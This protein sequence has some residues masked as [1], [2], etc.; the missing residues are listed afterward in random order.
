MVKASVRTNNIGI[1]L[2]W[3][4]V[5]LA[6][7]LLSSVL[8]IDMMSAFEILNKPSLSPPAYVFP[9]AWSIL[10]SLMGV[11][12]LLVYRSNTNSIYRSYGL[13]FNIIQLVLN[14]F[15]SIIFFNYKNYELALIWLVMLW[16]TVLAMLVYY[17]KVNKLAFVLD[18]PYILW[19]TFAGYLNYFILLNN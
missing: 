3:L 16:L 4:F 10:Y 14:F 17:S 11:G 5:P 8:T 13:M 6:V 12:A 18:V 19:L 2:L 15:W 7:G 9:I 1:S